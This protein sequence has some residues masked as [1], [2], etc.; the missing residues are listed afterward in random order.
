MRFNVEH[1]VDEVF[2]WVSFNIQLGLY[3]IFKWQQVT[4][5][6]V[7]L[8][9]SR[10]NCNPLRSISFTVSSE[11]LYIRNTSTPGISQGGNFINIYT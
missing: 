7:P 9:G 6:D 2:R 1:H 11:A 4:I 3:N 5:F 10:M 8:I